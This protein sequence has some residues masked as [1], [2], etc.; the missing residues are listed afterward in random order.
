MMPCLEA[1][2]GE[3]R[4]GLKE[5]KKGRRELAGAYKW[6]RKLSKEGADLTKTL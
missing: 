3:G 6:N 2:L 5:D 4:S 1:H